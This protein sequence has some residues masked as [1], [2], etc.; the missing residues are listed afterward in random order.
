MHEGTERECVY[1]KHIRRTL[2]L[3]RKK[4]SFFFQ[5]EE[6]KLKALQQHTCTAS[7]GKSYHHNQYHLSSYGSGDFFDGCIR[8]K[9]EACY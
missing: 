8:A 6:N 4:K 7:S 1:E 5:K 3:V 9:K 2:A